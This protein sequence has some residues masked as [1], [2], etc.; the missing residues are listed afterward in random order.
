MSR[1]SAWPRRLASVAAAPL[2]LAGC[3]AAS[4]DVV[5]EPG[6]A[7]LA[8]P[9]RPGVVIAAPPAPAGS[10]T[11][12][13]AADLARRTGFGLVAAG[14]GAPTAAA[15]Q[16]R[17]R[18]VAQGPLRLYAELH[19]APDGGAA[20]IAVATVGVDRDA[21]LRL[22]TLLE[23]IRDAHLRARPGPRPAVHVGPAT[24]IREAAGGAAD[25]A[26]LAERALRIEV[27]AAG[28]RGERDLYAA[29]LGDFLSEA[30]ALLRG[31]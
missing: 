13:L 30:L 28:I 6:A 2:V 19:A 27:P 11:A 24:S 5:P 16:A 9:G 14:P 22:Q 21:A 23:L 3:A 18:D 26:R 17:V 20:R 10:S 12:S 25:T 15:W 4:R 31:R 8:R 7:L 29:L 1:A